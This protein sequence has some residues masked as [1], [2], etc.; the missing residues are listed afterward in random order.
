MAAIHI[1]DRETD[2]L[3]RQLAKHLS[4][5][6]TDAINRA[7]RNELER[8]GVEPLTAASEPIAPAGNP[9]ELM[10]QLESVASGATREF[11]RLNARRKGKRPGS[12]FFPMLPRYGL[13]GTLE[14]YIDRPTSEGLKLCVEMERL[15]L[16]YETIVLDPKFETIVPAHI[17]AKAHA[18]LV[19]LGVTS[20][21]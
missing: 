8:E 9:D 19:A 14:R 18:N 7:A 10:K 4:V 13:I 5:G 2:A 12:Y 15:D 3:V 11:A 20:R 21:R 17:R 1:T 6:L 16:A